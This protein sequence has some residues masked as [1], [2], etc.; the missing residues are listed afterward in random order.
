[1][2]MKFYICETCGNIVAMVHESGVAVN[3]CGKPMKELIPGTD[4][5]AAKEKHIP[6]YEVKGD[7]VHVKVGSTSHPM[8]NDHYIQWIALET[9]QG[10]QRRV[11]QPGDEPKA[12]FSLCKGDKVVAVY[13]YC[14]L[15]GLWKA[16]GCGCKDTP[17]SCKGSSCGCKR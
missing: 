13:E 8:M 3:C 4:D 15:H 16:E 6:V 7:L 10:N 9:E 2:Q 14:N 5:T 11:L 1:M 17:C 12:C